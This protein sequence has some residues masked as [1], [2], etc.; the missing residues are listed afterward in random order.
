MLPSRAALLLVLAP[1]A[2]CGSSSSEATPTPPASTSESPDGG[3]PPPPIVDGAFQLTVPSGK[4][5]LMRGRTT[6]LTITLDRSSGYT[7][8]VSITLAGAPEGVSAERMDI[9]AGSTTGVMQI[10]VAARA[11]QGDLTGVTL[12]GRATGLATQ[13]LPLSAYVRGQ[14][15]EPDL[16]FGENGDAKGIGSLAFAMDAKG[17]LLASK[18]NS[19]SFARF[20]A[21]GAP[22]TTF[23]PATLPVLGVSQLAVVGD[24]IYACGDG[25]K[26]LVVRLT[27]AGA[28]DT[29]YAN[30]AGKVEIDKAGGTFYG[31]FFSSLGNAAVSFMSGGQRQLAWVDADGKVSAPSIVNEALDSRS[32]VLDGALLTGKAEIT[33]LVR[34]KVG[35]IYDL[36]FGKPDLGGSVLDVALAPSSFDVFALTSTN[37]VRIGTN[38]TKIGSFSS[39][40]QLLPST[41][42]G[43]LTFQKDGKLLVATNEDGGGRITRLLPTGALDTPFGIGGSTPITFARFVAV[44]PDGRIV[45]VAIEGLPVRRYWGD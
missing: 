42:G 27:E 31:C 29:T 33:K 2:A 24:K 19:S 22:D 35:S 26:V 7:G 16:T 17:R 28:I 25:P 3:G 5:L 12:E 4:L 37:V 20:T 9:P 45:V 40:L 30:G 39:A 34:V 10:V 43:V 15:G 36:I 21:D 8:M 11:S 6:P 23:Q 38:G 44:Q 18:N 41:I 32:A 1:L 14:P 13:S